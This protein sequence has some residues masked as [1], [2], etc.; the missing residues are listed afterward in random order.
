MAL[1]CDEPAP[2]PLGERAERIAARDVEFEPRRLPVH[3]D[4]AERQQGCHRPAAVAGDHQAE[5]AGGHERE[6]HGGVRFAGWMDVHGYGLR[7]EEPPEIGLVAE[8]HGRCAAEPSPAAQATI[9]CDRAPIP[10]WKGGGAGRKSWSQSSSWPGAIAAEAGT[11]KHEGRP[12]ERPS[13]PDQSSRSSQSAG[14][15]FTG[16]RR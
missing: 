15:Q 12:S 4:E 7:S 13:T 11:V 16:M 9:T 14:F 6:A 1:D 8:G 3:F 5:A 2:A 10:P